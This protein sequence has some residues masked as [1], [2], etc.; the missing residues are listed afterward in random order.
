MTAV[1]LPRK[2]GDGIGIKDSLTGQYVDGTDG[3]NLAV[4][5]EYNRLMKVE[6][7]LSRDPKEISVLDAERTLKSRTGSNGSTELRKAEYV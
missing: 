5:A 6:K 7:N 4:L 1:F 2:P 3:D